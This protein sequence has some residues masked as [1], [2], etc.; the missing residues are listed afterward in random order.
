LLVRSH[1]QLAQMLE[2]LQNRTPLAD[3][4]AAHRGDSRVPPGNCYVLPHDGEPRNVGSMIQPLDERDPELLEIFLEEA[5][6]IIESSSAALVRWQADPQNTLEVENLLRDLHTLKGGARMVE[7][8][9]IGDLAHELESLYEGLSSGALKT[10]ANCS[11][12]CC[13]AATTCS[14]TWSTP[15]AG[16]SRCPTDAADRQHRAVS[17]SGAIHEVGSKAP[18]EPRLPAP[19]AELADCR[20]SPDADAERTGP[21]MVKVA[22]EQLEDLVNLAGETSIF[23]GRIEQQVS[24]AQITLAEMETTIERMRDQLRRLD[25]ETQGR[26]LSRDRQTPNGWATKNSTR[27]KWIAIPSCSSCRGRCSS[28]RPT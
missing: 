4:G 22:A 26:I 16:M 11:T 21:E 20:Y 27:W 17:S 5:D 8:A 24:D 19:A 18:E 25:T 14:P 12:A 9:P 7:I 6:D 2:Q 15:F 10:S 28:P 23:R 13:K 1:D 3:P